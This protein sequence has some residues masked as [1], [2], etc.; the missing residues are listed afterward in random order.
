MLICG[1]ALDKAR[2]LSLSEGYR[3]VDAPSIRIS[4]DEESK[5]ITLE[6][7]GVGM[8]KMK[9]EKSRYNRSIWNKF[10]A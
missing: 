9:I 5:T 4:F 3:E 1:D 2:F 7:D 8:T 6:D 10:M